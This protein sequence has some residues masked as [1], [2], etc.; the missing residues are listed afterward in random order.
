MVRFDRTLKPKERKSKRWRERGET[1]YI[2]QRLKLLKCT[3]KVNGG[4][5]IDRR[6]GIH[7]KIQ[8]VSAVNYIGKSRFGIE[9]QRFLA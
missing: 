3:W 4:I 9:L 1:S 2:S 6:S 8:I 5:G 7:L